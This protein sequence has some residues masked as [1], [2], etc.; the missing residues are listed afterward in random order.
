MER[1]VFS[2]ALVRAA[3]VGHPR[4]APPATLG[5]LLTGEVVAAGEGVRQVRPGD[6][7]VLD[8]HPPCGHCAMCAAGRGRLCGRGDMHHTRRPRGVRAGDRGDRKGGAPHP[9]F[10]ALRRRGVHRIAR[11][12]ARRGPGRRR[13][14]ERPRPGGRQR[15]DGVPDRPGSPAEQCR[16]RH[17]HGEAPLQEGTD[18][19]GG[20]TYRGCPR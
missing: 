15:P 8:P 18:A 19:R 3:T 16:I 1:S 13:G 20:R 4:V 10:P 11:L 6:R 14:A 2:A 17:L 7:V 9:G 12:S 5:I